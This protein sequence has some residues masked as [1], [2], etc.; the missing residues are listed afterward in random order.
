MFIC[1][2]VY[3]CLHICLVFGPFGGLAG[4]GLKVDKYVEYLHRCVRSG[5][6]LCVEYALVYS[7][8]TV[9]V[10]SVAMCLKLC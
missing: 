4:L 10:P 8:L 9:D 3:L 6:G 7:S 2:P 5:A 1:I